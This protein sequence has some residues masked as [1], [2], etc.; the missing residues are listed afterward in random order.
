MKFLYAFTILNTSKIYKKYIMINT[1]N[2]EY[3]NPNPISDFMSDISKRWYYSD[4]MVRC[5]CKV[6]EKSWD[7]IYWILCKIGFEVHDMP[8]SEKAEIRIMEKLGFEKKQLKLI[9]NKLPILSDIANKYKNTVVV[10]YSDEEKH[11]ICCKNGK[12]YDSWDSGNLHI[13]YIWVLKEKKITIEN[14]L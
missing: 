8:S 7:D 12:Y 1:S 5:I 6:T 3:Y 2:W 14:I 4:C 11:V 13:N 10:C 9:N